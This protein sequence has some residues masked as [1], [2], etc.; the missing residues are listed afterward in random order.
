LATGAV[1]I[2]AKFHG[3]LGIPF[4]AFLPFIGVT[5]GVYLFH[6]Q[7]FVALPSN[8]RKKN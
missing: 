8:K 2:D 3:D 6:T 5:V 4:I 7:D 1:V